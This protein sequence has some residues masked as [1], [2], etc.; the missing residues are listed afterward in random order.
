MKTLTLAM[1]VKNEIKVLE[2]VLSVAHQFADK[3]VVVDTGSTDGTIELI[4]KYN[5]EYFHYDWNNNFGEARNFAFSKA[6]TDYIMWL[7]ADDIVSESEIEKINIFKQNSDDVDTL[8]CKYVMNTDQDGNPLFWFYRER[9][10]KNCK[11]AKWEG[12]IHEVITPFGKVVHS[13]ITVLHS[14][15]N[16]HTKRNLSIFR[17]MLKNGEQL[18]TRN[19]FY[20][21]RELFYAGHYKKSLT[22]FNKY[23]AKGDCF[24]PDKVE[25]YKNMHAIYSKLNCAEKAVQCLFDSLKV[26]VRSDIACL[27]GDHYCNN[28][29]YATA[30][31]WY[32]TAIVCASSMDVNVAKGFVDA[33]C[34]KYIP[35]VQLCV[36]YD[37]LGNHDLA[38]HY[39]MKVKDLYPT[40]NAVLFNDDYFKNRGK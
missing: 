29:N 31:D 15:V 33:R 27:L 23:L 21:A 17:Q 13:D 39:H 6:T 3:I 16:S 32:K 10:V 25:A 28:Q 8:M 38:Y 2:R 1:I 12:A 4:K 26:F 24:P 40:D 37:R 7:D 20:Y 18:N 9:I 30:I 19:L 14:P 11:L 22:V 36:C 34:E 35:Y 5:A